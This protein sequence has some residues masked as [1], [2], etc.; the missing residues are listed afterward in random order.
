M[1][2]AV[3]VLTLMMMTSIVFEELLA[4]D[5]NTLTYTHRDTLRQAQVSSKQ[6]NAKS[7]NAF[8]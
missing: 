5:T 4:R 6:Q 8:S 3:S 7:T 2:E 1:S